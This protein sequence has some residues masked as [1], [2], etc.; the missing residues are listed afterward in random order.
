MT[1][2]QAARFRKGAA[3]LNYL[4]QDRI[5]VA[6]ASK[7]VSRF[8]SDPR[9][10]DEAVLLRVVKYLRRFPRLI[11]LYEWQEPVAEV[12]VY[13]DSDWGGCVSSRR[14]TSGG[15]VVHGKHLIQHWSKTQQLIALS[16]AE[17]ELN[18][19]VKSG[20]EG[21]GVAHLSQELGEACFVRIRGDS[22]ANDGVIKRQ[23][24]GRI[25]HLTVRQLWLQQ[26]V[27]MKVATHDKVPRMFNGS[28]VLKHHWTKAEGDHHFPTFGGEQAFPSNVRGNASARPEGGSGGP[29]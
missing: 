12:V 6:Y 14:S 20:Q 2:A 25:K 26:Q 23:G 22:S 1:A 24:C 16:S 9:A 8:M 4:S 28:D 15:A 11:T 3:I 5:D 18:A 17:A 21:L 10:G 29:G 19:A 27:S 7:E 13:S